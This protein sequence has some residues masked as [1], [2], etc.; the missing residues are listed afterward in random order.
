[1]D[2]R[3]SL[4]TLAVEDLERSAHFYAAL[5]WRCIETKGEDIVTF[6]LLGQVLGLYPRQRLAQ[7]LGVCVDT[8][9]HGAMTLGHNVRNTEQVDL[10]MAKA[11]AAGAEIVKQASEVFWGGYGGYFRDPDGHIWEVSYN[12][13]SKLGPDGAFRWNGY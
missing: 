4:I 2:Q 3:V 5:G 10:L 13:F 11:V 12:P 7:D 1:M 8:L 9:G 6:D